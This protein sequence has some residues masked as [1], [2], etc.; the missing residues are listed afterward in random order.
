MQ[1]YEVH[2]PWTTST[3]IAILSAIPTIAY[4][5]LQDVSVQFLKIVSDQNMTCAK[6]I[7]FEIFVVYSDCIQCL[8]LYRI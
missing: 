2:L 6:Q 8:S 5:Q 1:V 3:L 7:L 4:I